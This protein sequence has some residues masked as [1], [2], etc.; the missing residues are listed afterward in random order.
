VAD[1]AKPVYVDCVATWEDD[2]T[3]KARV[4]EYL[5]STP[6]PYGFDPATLFASLDDPKYGLLRL[7]P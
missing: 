2:P 7:M 5:K 6:E 3:E 1:V 4:W